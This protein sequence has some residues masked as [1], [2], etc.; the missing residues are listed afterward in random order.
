MDHPKYPATLFGRLDF[1]CGYS[2]NPPNVPPSEIRLKVKPE[3]NKPLLWPDVYVRGGL[4]HQSRL[5][6]RTFNFGSLCFGGWP[7]KNE[8]CA[9]ILQRKHHDHFPTAGREFLQMVVRSKGIQPKMLGNPPKREWTPKKATPNDIKPKKIRLKYIPLRIH[10]TNGI[11]P[12]IE[13]MFI[14]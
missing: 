12:Y 4:V 9:H 5:D 10:G 11:F 2:T 13:C 6:S 7:R 14:I 3:V 8:C 1:H